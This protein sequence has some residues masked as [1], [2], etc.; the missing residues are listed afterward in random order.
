MDCLWI[1]YALPVDVLWIPHGVD[2]L[3]T[4][5][6]FPVDSLR[7]PYE[8][9]TDPLWKS[10]RFTMA[11]PW[12]SYGFAVHPLWIPHGVPIDFLWIPFMVS[13]GTGHISCQHRKTP[14]WLCSEVEGGG[15][16]PDHHYPSILGS[17]GTKR[18][19]TFSFLLL[20]ENSKRRWGKL[21]KII[22]PFICSAP[23]MIEEPCDAQI[24][25]CKHD[26]GR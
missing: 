21:T 7:M 23:D 25:F 10:H 17:G 11:S 3:R 9:P 18:L 22:N 5:Y 2:L 4:S 16:A 6:G 26:K 8:C 14:S 19:E 15:G 1:C 13:N 12:I 20:L 24:P